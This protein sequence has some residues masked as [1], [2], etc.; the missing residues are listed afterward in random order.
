MSSEPPPTPLALKRQPAG[1]STLLTALEAG[2]AAIRAHH[3]D[4]PPAQIVIGQGSGQRGSLLLGH[5]APERW[6]PA[7]G[8]A[9]G[10]F[11]HELLIGGE[12]LA[13]GAADVFTTQLHEAAH[14]LALARRIQDTSRDGRYHNERYQTLAQELGLDVERDRDLG[15][16][17]TTLQPQTRARYQAAITALEH[18]ITLHRRPDPAGRP[19]RNLTAALCAC[20]RRIRVAPRTLAAGAIT[21]EIC[22]QPF[23]RPLT[24]ATGAAQAVPPPAPRPQPEE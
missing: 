12:G 10:E 15:W 23:T 11:V 17:T 21:C 3:P 2:W 5:L 19:G 14:A 4:L 1:A 6:Q 24:R 16:S 9:G 22:R 13:R 8:Q 18:A 20:P 7:A